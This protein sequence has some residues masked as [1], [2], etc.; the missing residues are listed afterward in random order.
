MCHICPPFHIINLPE[1]GDVHISKLAYS[2]VRSH[3]H[4]IELV[5]TIDSTVTCF[6]ICFRE[7]QM[8]VLW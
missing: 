7:L 5:M 8:V 1:V 4:G 2:R 3:Q 6:L